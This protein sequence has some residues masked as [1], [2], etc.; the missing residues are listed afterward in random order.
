VRT[1]VRTGVGD[2]T[3]V[4]VTGKL[5]R[6]AGASE[7]TWEAFDGTEAILSGDLSELS[8]GLPVRVEPGQ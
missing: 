8:D 3:W 2:G 7:G 1:P 4:K 6:P 5:V